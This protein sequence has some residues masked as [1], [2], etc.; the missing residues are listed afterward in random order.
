MTY[1]RFVTSLRRYG[2]KGIYD[3]VK[4]LFTTQHEDPFACELRQRINHNITPTRGVTVI[5]DMSSHNSLSK[6]LSD[7]VLSLSETDIPYQAYDTT[8]P[9]PDTFVT[10]KYSDIITMFHNVAIPTLSSCKVHHIVFWEFDT[11]F[12]YAYPECIDQTTLLTMSEY[13]HTTVHSQIHP[14]TK[15]EYIRYPFHFSSDAIISPV[16]IRKQFDIP[17]SAFMVFFNFD[18][19]SSYYRKNPEGLLRAF[20]KAFADIPSAILVFK[21]NGGR[22]RQEKESKLKKLVAESSVASQVRFIDD[23]IT[24]DELV[25]LTN[26]CD[27]Y[28]SLH[29]G[30]GF[31]LG[32]AEAM[33]LGKAVVVSDCGSTNEFCTSESAMLVPH[34]MVRIQPWQI[35]RN[36]YTWVSQ[37]PEPNINAAAAAMR[38]L[39]DDTGLRT[40]LGV[41]GRQFISNH[42]SP[43]EVKNSICA[44]IYSQAQ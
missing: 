2:I 14:S 17:D 40:R 21:T 29:R 5:G 24:T 19:R 7:L 1:I 32:V 27:V 15:V 28:A 34:T 23:F 41:S 25:S 11:G 4:R 9:M 33:S 31:G 10:N 18:Y 36:D 6:V 35:D 8:K 26:A 16:A 12:A 38:T 20:E 39:Y 22:Q 42:F 37:W 43:T 13:C 30:E 44:L 3:W